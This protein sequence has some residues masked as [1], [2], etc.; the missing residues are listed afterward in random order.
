MS[1]HRRAAKRDANES[2][3][4]KALGD[5]GA[6]VWP[7]SD[8]GIPDLLVGYR[9]RWILLEVKNGREGLTDAQEVFFLGSEGLPRHIVRTV[10]E[11]ISAVCLD[12]GKESVQK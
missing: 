12:P 9:G 7:L 5:I 8:E 6:K 1:L 3:I 4:V 2:E 11:A 10:P